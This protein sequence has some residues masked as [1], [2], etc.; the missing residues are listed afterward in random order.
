[1]TSK[2]TKTSGLNKD[3]HVFHR[4]DAAATY[5]VTGFCPVCKAR[6]TFPCYAEKHIVRCRCNRS[7]CPAEHGQ[8][9][10]TCS[11]KR[12][13]DPKSQKDMEGTKVALFV[14]GAVIWEE[15]FWQEALMFWEWQVLE[16]GGMKVG[17][18]CL[19]DSESD[20]DSDD[21]YQEMQGVKRKRMMEG[22]SEEKKQR[23]GGD[24]E[25]EIES[26]Y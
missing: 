17:S 16:D 26:D 13:V 2:M 15:G 12:V 5:L 6:P 4:N 23:V 22:G 8:K 10:I 14:E 18:L 19:S 3:T 21:E 7:L 20:S 24:V 25:M 11:G 1:M 9:C